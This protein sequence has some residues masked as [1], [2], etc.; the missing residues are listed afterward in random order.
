TGATT[1]T[2]TLA[3]SGA[4]TLG[5]A[6]TVTTGGVTVSAGGAAITG[7]TSVTG[8][9][10]VSGTTTMSSGATIT[11]NGLTIT[12][13]GLLVSDT[14]AT[15]SAGGLHVTGATAL[16]TGLTVTSG[17]SIADGLTVSSGGAAITG[18]LSV[19]TTTTM[20][21]GATISAGGLEVTGATTMHSG[22]SISS[23]ASIAGGLT[24]A[25]TGATITG[26]VV[27][28]STTDAS[29][30]STGVLQVAGGIGVAGTIWSDGTISG[31]TNTQRSDARL[32]TVLG[33][34]T[35]SRATLDA[36][37]PVEFEWNFPSASPGVQAGFLAQDVA[38][39]LP[40]LVTTG[41]DGVLSMNYIGLIPYLV[42]YVQT[43]EPAN[44]SSCCAHEA[45]RLATLELAVA[46]ASA[47]A[48]DARQQA[49]GL[50]KKLA[51]YTTKLAQLNAELSAK[52]NQQ[53]KIIA[54]QA[55]LLAQVLKAFPRTDDAAAQ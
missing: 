49:T 47:E 45:G 38:R 4:T 17:A 41:V 9:L 42:A 23:G 55:Q 5:N 52:L 16:N 30:S 43:L 48:L 20:S 34:A 22:V 33:P 27:L 50:S 32:K 35:L 31:L 39:A 25:D 26:T 53:D 37:R 40:H 13:G 11:A 6:V 1:L 44:A 24:L 10:T 36:L 51:D 15:I 2:S 14:G 29:S 8:G 54:E 12:S 28:S 19:S 7:A 18:A 21:N 46:T 3:V